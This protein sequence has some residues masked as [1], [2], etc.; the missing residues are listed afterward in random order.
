LAI[1]GSRGRKRK[2]IY[3]VRDDLDGCVEKVKRQMSR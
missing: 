2:D 3:E 1:G